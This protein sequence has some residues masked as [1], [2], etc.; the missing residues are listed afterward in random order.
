MARLSAQQIKQTGKREAAAYLNTDLT[1]VAAS[2][3]RAAAVGVDASDPDVAQ[4]TPQLDEFM[5]LILSTDRRIDDADNIDWC[6]W[7]IAGG[8]ELDEFSA[9][10]KLESSGLCYLH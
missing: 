5:N 8:R 4:R 10:G 1:S 3:S 9:I 6:M 7:L 2:A